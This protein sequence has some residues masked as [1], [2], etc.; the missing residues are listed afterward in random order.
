MFLEFCLWTSS[1]IVIIGVALEELPLFVKF[2]KSGDTF[3]VFLFKGGCVFAAKKIGF[4]LLIVGL[5]GELLFQTLVSTRDNESMRLSGEK[6]AKLEY[7]AKDSEQHIAEANARTASAIAVGE[8][9][10]RDAAIAV[11]QV[12][13][14][15]A[16]A[17]KATKA[18]EIE[19]IERLKLESQIAPRRLNIDQQQILKTAL[20]QFKGADISVTSYA[21]DGDA[22]V[23]GGQLLTI[24]HNAKL[25]PVDRRMS[26]SP[27]GSISFG[28]YVKGTNS[29]LVK[30]L[31]TTLNSF[32]I[33]TS[34]GEPP[35]SGGI[36]AGDRDAPHAA[37]IFVGIKPLIK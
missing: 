11:A 3:P 36:S 17:A 30:T 23:F 27:V 18:A 16:R 2:R 4:I 19:R 26:E 14:A 12:A 5:M 29:A 6:I 22:V 20:S 7:E 35:Q 32:E 31:L 37:K 33:A 8:Q 15:K 21:L 25:I 24:I 9:A 13:D 1:A 28:V 34:L 10:K